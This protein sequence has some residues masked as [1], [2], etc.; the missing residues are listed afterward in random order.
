MNNRDYELAKA[1]TEEAA[2]SERGG[3]NDPKVGAVLIK[4]GNEITLAHRGEFEKGEHA[5][6]TLLQK[7]LRSK[8]RTS[9]ATLYTTLEPCTTRTHDKLPCAD[10]IIQKGIR[11][12]IIGIL[13][14][15][16]TICGR[17]YW[18]LV[19]AGID[20]ELFP[21]ELSRQI[22]RLNNRF[23]EL[24]RGGIPMTSSVAR[25]I[26]NKKSQI[27]S[28]YTGLGWGD[29][30][31]LQDCP[32][33]R[34]G[35]PIGRVDLILEPEK[36]FELPP[37]L[38]ESYKLYVSAHVQ[39]RRFKD[40]KEKLMLAINPV[41][42]SDSS[43]LALNVIRTTW[44]HIQFYKDNIATVPSLRD[45]L[46]DNLVRGSLRADFP[47]ALCMHLIVI[48]QDHKVLLTKRSPK[49]AYHP[50]SWSASVEE[51][52]DI[53]DL[54]G[55]TE[56]DCRAWAVRFLQEELGLGPEGY[57]ADTIRILSVFLESDILGISL[58]TT[59]ELSLSSDDLIPILRANP[60]TD[61]EFTE[62]AFL[63]CERES[64][65]TELLNPSKRYHPT[66]EYRLLMTFL[67]YFGPPTSEEITLTGERSR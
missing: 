17:G 56:T 46:I 45:P 3:A 50:N 67:K 41:S 29:A 42:F 38:I 53:Q 21:P 59:V 2:K 15:N 8:D 37:N 63:D 27:I 55:K 18:R 36:Q 14:P 7:K 19:D 61:Y 24:H 57:H 35:W 51:Q 23:V 13:D 44:F 43:S 26:Q 58:C 62:W 30:L 60:R 40:D 31:S 12:V 32:N 28:P 25:M 48:T 22:L 20:V 33:V 11:K 10:W 34:E 5:E 66:T 6:F 39:D 9:G 64:L 16:P 54:D 65:M 1:A 4:D 47:N 49:V 52:L